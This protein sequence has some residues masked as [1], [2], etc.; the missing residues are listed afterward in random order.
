MK[1]LSE[2]ELKKVVGGLDLN[3]GILNSFVRAFEI[4]LEIG[5]S[6]GTSIRRISGSSICE[7]E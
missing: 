1:E 6:F 4:I 3:A 7:I 5:R 2:E